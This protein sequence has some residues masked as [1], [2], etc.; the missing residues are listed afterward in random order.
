[1]DNSPAPVEVTYEPEPQMEP[2]PVVGEVCDDPTINDESVY[3]G[4]VAWFY[5]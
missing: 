5:G 1:M 3:G 4:Y 2:V